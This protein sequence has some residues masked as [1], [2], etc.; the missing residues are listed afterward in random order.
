MPKDSPGETENCH[1]DD[2]DLALQSGFDEHPGSAYTV[3][4]HS[5]S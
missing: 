2:C 3:K 1:F 4:L 5:Q